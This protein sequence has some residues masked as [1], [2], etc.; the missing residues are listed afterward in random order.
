MIA[1][2]YKT[3]KP[4]TYNPGTPYEHTV[5]TFLALVS[6]TKTFEQVQAECDQLNRE[7]PERLWN[8]ELAYCNERTYFARKMDNDYFKD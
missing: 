6:Y 5:D 3:S 8:G 4:T 1:Y 7:K 2:M